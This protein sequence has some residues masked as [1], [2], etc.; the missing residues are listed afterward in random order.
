MKTW[1]SDQRT[2]DRVARLLYE[3]GPSTAA[4]LGERLGLTPAA[5][6]RH[7]DGMLLEGTITGGP[8]RSYGPRGR[9]RP[10]RVFA[11]T[12][13]GH[14]GMPTTYDDLASAALRFV[15]ER[16]G[17]AA[18]T[19]FAQ[20]RGHELEERYRPGVQA[21][22]PQARPY[23]LAEAMSADGYAATVH[24]AGVGVQVCQHHCPVQ[25]VAAQ[26]PQICDAETEAIGR[27]L[28]THVQR[29]AT[30]AHGDGVCTTHI[31]LTRPT[32]ERT[33]R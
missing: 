16:A 1:G 25:H 22:R 29:L 31:P 18:V 14:E 3:L 15:A 11:L 8:E 27:L 12:D 24:E 23:A 20:A 28:G 19:E 7:L 26:F 10:A 5:I 21:A 33:K 13:L 32:S 9:G 6:R 2:R 30:I 17:V 4:R